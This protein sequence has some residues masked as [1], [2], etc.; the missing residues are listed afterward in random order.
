MARPGFF[1]NEEG[2]M[3]VLSKSFFMFALGLAGVSMFASTA[4]GQYFRPLLKTGKG[5]LAYL[6]LPGT[7]MPVRPI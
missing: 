6:R 4:A 5:A 2:L 3:N 1:F 7:A